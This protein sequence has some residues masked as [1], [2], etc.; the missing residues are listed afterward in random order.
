MKRERYKNI[1]KCSNGIFRGTLL[2]VVSVTGESARFFEV[3]RSFECLNNCN[4]YFTDFAFWFVD[5]SIMS[6]SN[7][8][9]IIWR[10]PIKIIP[11]S[12]IMLYRLLSVFAYQLRKISLDAPFPP[13]LYK[14]LLHKTRYDWFDTDVIIT[15]WCLSHNIVVEVA[16]YFTAKL[17]WII[18]DK[19]RNTKRVLQ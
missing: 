9:S 5:K 16:M 8:Q 3:R 7:T 4:I 13:N 6:E 10:T 2:W 18:E 15:Q 11:S 14:Q 12:H 19:W 17:L 1:P